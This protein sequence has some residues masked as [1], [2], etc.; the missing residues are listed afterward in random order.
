MKFRLLLEETIS[1]FNN[2]DNIEKNPEI[3]KDHSLDNIHHETSAYTINSNLINKKLWDDKI[4][5][6]LDKSSIGSIKQINNN[7]DT[8]K[9]ASLNFNVFSGVR[10]DPQELVKNSNGILHHSAFLSTSAEPD[11]ALSFT[12]PV[13]D[14][15][16]NPIHHILNIT[17]KKGQK[18]GAYIGH[19]SLN[20][21]EKEFLVKANQVMRI[22]PNPT[23]YIDKT[24]RKVRVHNVSILDNDEINNNKEHPEIQSKLN[25]DKRLY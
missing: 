2:F 12:K 4:Y 3:V 19:H 13:K 20:P 7:L 22:H 8:A 10:R 14:V 1:E 25:F 18:V 5:R 15:D 21:G 16:G 11:A 9:N 23:D 24:G 6:D 17:V